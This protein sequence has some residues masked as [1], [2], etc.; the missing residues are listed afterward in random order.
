MRRNESSDGKWCH[1]YGIRLRIYKVS[2]E[3]NSH[4]RY[5][6]DE[7]IRKVYQLRRGG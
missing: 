6:R 2:S 5:D 4:R 3:P 1:V 7:I